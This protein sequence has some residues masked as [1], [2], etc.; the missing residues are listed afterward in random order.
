MSFFKKLADKFDD[1]TVDDERK[2]GASGT[3]P[4]HTIQHGYLGTA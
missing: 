1:L 4:R 3:Y 2:T